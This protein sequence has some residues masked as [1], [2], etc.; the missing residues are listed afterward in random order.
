[1]VVA[2]DHKAAYD[3]DR[4]PN[5]GGMGCYAPAPLMSS[6]LVER[7]TREVLQPTVDGMAARGTRY[8][9]ILYAGLM[10]DAPNAGNESKFR[11][12]EFNCRFGDP[13]AQV[14]LPLL[15][16]DLVEVLEACMDGQ[17]G[18]PPSVPPMQ[19]TGGRMA[20]WRDASATCV[21]M[22]SGGY[23]GAY[24]R[25][26]PI[27]GLEAANALPGVTVFH[28][29]TRQEGGQ[30]LTN[31][32]RVLGVTAVAPTLAESVAQAYA[33]VAQI[34]FEGAMCR[35]DIGAKGLSG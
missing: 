10:L 2:Q 15:E 20:R 18:G 21:V 25:G 4:G 29:G 17:L 28:A 8:V 13:E 24:E 31:G 34:G 22:A 9:G 23:P 1:M 6:S 12:L 33:G 26:K 5:T 3:G 16:T 35:T 27:T 7:V 11:V 19:L 14:I 30:V 32:G